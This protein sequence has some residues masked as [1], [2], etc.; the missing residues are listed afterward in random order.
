MDQ[1]SQ[2]NNLSKLLQRFSFNE[3]MAVAAVHSSQAILF[4]QK[5]QQNQY[6]GILPWCLETFVMLS[7]EATEYS[8]K[9]FRSKNE[10]KFVKMCNAILEATVIASDTICDKFSF[11]D[12]FM[13]VTGLTQF[14]IQEYYM[15][16]QYR[17]WTIFNDDSQ[18]VCL[19][20]VFEEKM[21][22]KYEDYL[23]LGNV[24]Q[25]LSIIHAEYK[26][27]PIPKNVL[28]YLLY[29][30][31]PEAASHLKISRSDYVEL[32]KQYAGNSED[33]YKY[34][35]SLR[36]SYRFSFIEERNTIYCP[37][38]HL[39]NENI[40]SALFYRITDGD[41][42]LRDMIGKNIWEKY[43]LKII[44]ESNIYDEVYPEQSYQ[45]NGSIAKSPDVLVRQ[46]DE[47]L[48]IDSK[49]T[50]PNIGIRL[51]N[52]K[53]HEKHINIVAQNIVKLYNQIQKDIY[54]LR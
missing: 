14:Y 27:E 29:E 1:Y 18:P 2:Y 37:L 45:N 15:I 28:N 44:E 41:N 38:P 20:T 12:M 6:T 3:K 46:G 4:N 32:Q 26:S 43:L 36:P 23:I 47:V 49:S 17:Y 40:T 24:L 53:S 22:T 51:L 34:V 54:H 10:N 19:K 25:L 50:V 48:F 7:I 33:P 52:A 42:T 31:F 21:G 16:R 39:L 13:P 30:R 9:D 5:M 11:L 35:Y 8:N